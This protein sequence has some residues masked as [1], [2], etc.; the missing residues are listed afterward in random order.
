MSI[1]AFLYTISGLNVLIL[2]LVFLGP[3][4][5]FISQN[6]KLS[7]EKR[8]ETR[9]SFDMPNQYS[10]TYIV[11]HNIRRHT[12]NNAMIFMPPGDRKKGSFR[13]AATQRLFPREI[14]FGDD[15]DFDSLLNS[16]WGARSVFF[17]FSNQW[18]PEICA[19]KAVI[20]L[21]VPGFGMCRIS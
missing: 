7:M 19:G 2:I 16:K 5:Y 3:K 14:A 8:M 6:S 9:G 15:K 13:S 12:L 11:V 1:K 18:K 4:W 10:E 20:G 17:V 21:G